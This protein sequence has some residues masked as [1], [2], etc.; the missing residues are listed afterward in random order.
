MTMLM[1]VS[2]S[3]FAQHSFNKRPST[4]TKG[5]KTVAGSITCNETNYIPGATSDIGFNYIHNS[6]DLEYTDGVSLTFPAGVSVNNGED[7]AD[8]D[9]SWNGETGE[10]V[11]TTWGNMEG[12]SGFGDLSSASSFSVNI[13]IDP[14]FTGNL[15]ITWTI[16]GDGYG[17]TPHE[18]TGIITLTP[19]LDL[20]LGV[21]SIAP[22]FVETGT[23]VNPIV[24]VKNFG[25]DV[26]TTWS[27]SLTDGGTY[28]STI[29]D[30]AIN[31]GQTLELVMD[32]WTP[33]AG[34]QTLV[35][36]ITFLE[37][38]NTSNNTLSQNVSVS[39]LTN[40]FAWDAYHEGGVG[41]T[42]E[43]PINIILQ[44]GQ[45][46]QIALDDSDFI[47][48]ADYVNNDIYGIRYSDDVSPLVKIDPSTGVV[49]NIGGGAPDLTGFTYDITTGT[50]YVM[51]FDGVLYTIDLETGA[52]TEIGGDYDA[53]ISLACN[54]AGELYAISLYGTLA[55]INKTTGEA[56]IIGDLGIDIEYAQDMGFDRDNNILYGALY[57]SQGGIYIINTTTGVADLVVTVIDE[58]TG[59]AVPYTVSGPQVVAKTPANNEINVE[60]DAE[61]SVTFNVD[62][63]EV[64][65]DYITITP[66]PSFEIAI[67]ENKLLFLN[68]DL[69]Y[70][71]TYTVF[72][73]AGAISDGVDELIYDITWSFKT[74]LDVTACNE[75]ANINISNIQEY[76]ADIQ[77]TE[78][79][80]G[81]EWVVAYG[82]AGF[83]PET[84]GE[85]VTVDATNITIEELEDNTTYEVYVMALCGAD[86]TS[87]WAGPVS[88]T[89]L[90]YCDDITSLPY[91]E[92]FEGGAFPPACW[93]VINTNS[94]PSSNWHVAT[95]SNN[96]NVAELL[97]S[98]GEMMDEWL[99]SPKFNLSGISS[100]ISLTF[101]FFMS[102]YW[103]VDPNNGADLMLKVS[104]D[105]G[106][107]WTQLW[108]EEDYGS[109]ENF[110]WYT[111]S[112]SLNAYAGQN[113]V[114]FAFHFYGDDG[115][116]LQLD[117]IK[118]DYAAKAN[119]NI[120]NL[121]S[122]Y[123]N[124]SNGLVNVQVTE[125]SVINVVDL[126]GRIVATYN[127]SANEAFTF[128]QASG[129]YI[130][131]VESKGQVS[132]H[133]LIVE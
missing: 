58:L 18:K 14:S 103:Q 69:D 117:N 33:E 132:T 12:N 99:I 50:A 11:T 35:A 87:D 128:N 98:N 30:Q 94:D 115:A 104:T 31:P 111:T 47:A 4:P 2:V 76:Q 102:Y 64:D 109:F 131:K 62:I 72:I 17:S 86:I 106:L 63:F 124:P 68:N 54:S 88:F 25:A 44:T 66:D 16:V 55:S 8:D 116:Q 53:T 90:L 113:S 60:I 51:D 65:F 7:F 75:P 19:A 74:M 78:T 121:V 79:G 29:E 21:I 10:G 27:L 56:A 52:T 5:T 61:I 127:V 96:S 95:D 45:M 37:D 38:E 67:D 108:R 83:D 22:L 129:M 120:A 114:K 49:T 70:N 105:N 6:P 82:T 73:S 93:N 71:T 59:F 15:E 110:T 57:T 107:T 3:S 125:N 122:V 126:A 40:A 81:T 20:D 9:I 23:T 34:N 118:L 80:A 119:E 36:T 39:N 97:Y 91:I 48:A 89:T 24:K 1:F 13:T 41:V 101:D 123:P 133:K 26:P 130:L 77:W 100:N 85:Q 42:G 28:T 46:S 84:E 112:V 32:D 43:G 92:N